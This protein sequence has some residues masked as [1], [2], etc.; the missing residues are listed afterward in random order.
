MNI[1]KK[2]ECHITFNEGKHR[3]RHKLKDR[4]K[5][6][7]KYPTFFSED[8]ISGKF[9]IIKTSGNFDY[10]SITIELIGLI[11]N[12][13]DSKSSVRF[14]SLSKEISKNG[15]LT[16]DNTSYNF[17][18]KNVKLPY[19]SYKGDVIGVKYI[20]KVNIIKTMRTISYEEEFAVVKPNDES[21]LKKN[22]EPI[23]MNV[24]I[25]ELLSILIEFDHIN[26][27][28]H[29]TL[30]GFVSFGKVN[31]LLTKM[32]V[33]L[34]KKETIFGV[35]AQ[36]NPKPKVIATFELIDGGPFKNETIPFRFFLEP[37][38]LTPT[39]TDVAGNFSVRY[40]LNLI[41]KDEK[42]NRYF[43]Q[44]EIFLYR[45]Y[46]KNNKSLYNTLNDQNNNMNEIE[47][48]KDF[49]TE[50]ID[51]G[52]YFS[53]FNDIDEEKEN[54]KEK[55]G[56]KEPEPDDFYYRSTLTGFSIDNEEYEEEQN[57]INNR[58]LRNMRSNTTF[59][60]RKRNLPILDDKITNR[61]TINETKKKSSSVKN[62]N[63][64]KGKKG[65]NQVINIKEKNKYKNNDILINDN[66]YNTDNY[67]IYENSYQNVFDDKLKKNRIKYSSLSEKNKIDDDEEDEKQKSTSINDDSDD[68][69]IKN[70]NP[71]VNSINDYNLYYP[72]EP[73]SNT[74]IMNN[75]PSNYGNIGQSGDFRQNL[76][77]S[78][79]KN[80]KK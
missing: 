71:L 76:M 35:A 22:D 63:S 47:Q 8:D 18:F 57:Q 14:L 27:G 68:N 10:S 70:S 58:S 30:K 43:K 52:D 67:I 6:L 40:Y 53:V 12:Y 69:N 9:E 15:S 72:N 65:K 32:E 3:H 21:I 74:L 24:G 31:M 49:I 19:E 17:N 45:L 36:R 54:V 48:L 20:I 25:K 38:N 44:K 2:P 79:I 73:F 55:K 5:K 80:N 7:I 29:G 39:Y 56:I 16:K 77:G 60:I 23:S 41:M 59:D 1:F 13:R 75:F 11:D 42:Y 46:L 37:Y 66:Y 28:I 4:N 33:Q 26:Y 78:R 64:G 34:I 51:Y 50:P 62:K 61:N